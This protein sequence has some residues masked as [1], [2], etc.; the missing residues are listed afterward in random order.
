MITCKV[1]SQKYDGDTCVDECPYC[2]WIETF[3]QEGEENEYDSVNGMTL[4][5]ARSRY[6]KGL[7][8]WGEPLPKVRPQAK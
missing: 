7:N 8:I 2:D 4:A 1:C 5:T 3:T 6:A